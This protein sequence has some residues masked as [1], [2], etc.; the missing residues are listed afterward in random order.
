MSHRAAVPARHKLLDAAIDAI[1]AKGY[2]AT[3]VDDICREAGVTKGSFFHHFRS[4]DELAIAAAHQ[5]GAFAEALFAQAPFRAEP[6]PLDRLLGYVALRASML[7]G[8]LSRYTCFFG[9]LVQ[10]TYDTHPAIRAACAQGLEAHVAVLAQDVALAKQR[11]APD[12]EWSAESVARYMQA[13]LQGSFIFAK[14]M[15]SPAIA[16]ENLAHLERHLVALFPRP[17]TRQEIP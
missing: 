1:R 13:V 14:A 9:V 16:R 8:E 5:F 6:D 10:E 4:K 12:A 7:E 15:Q 17:A 11:Y 2:A 3:T